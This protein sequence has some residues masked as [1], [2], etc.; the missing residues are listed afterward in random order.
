[1]GGARTG[2]LEEDGG[3]GGHVRGDEPLTGRTADR[4]GEV[5]G[6]GG[7]EGHVQGSA[8]G[9]EKQP[10]SQVPNINPFPCTGSRQW[11]GTVP[12]SGKEGAGRDVH[13]T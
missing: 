7:Q 1:M 9:H 12:K 2:V 5:P 11:P 3:E 4:G 13:A 6:E 10:S 8:P